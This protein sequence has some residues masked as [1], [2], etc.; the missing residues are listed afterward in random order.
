M[1]NIEP[2]KSL[3]DDGLPTPEMGSWGEEKHRHMQLYA[4]LFVK[5]DL[6]F[7]ERDE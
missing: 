7:V 3:N 2:L 4:S 5:G 6:E 1:A